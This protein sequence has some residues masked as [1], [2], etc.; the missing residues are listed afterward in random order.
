LL[1]KTWIEKDQI[2]RKV[3]EGDTEKKKKEL[4]DFIARK[5]DRLI[6]EQEDNSKKQNKVT[7]QE[8]HKERG[9]FINV[10][11]ME[12]VLKDLYIQEISMSTQEVLRKGVFTSDHLREP[13]QCEATALGEDKNKNGK[14]IPETIREIQIIRNKVRNINKKKISWKIY[15]NLQKS[16]RRLHRLEPRRKQVREI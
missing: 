16:Y 15:K 9:L 12:E 7:A 13:Q 2:K 5:I 1:G 3:E 6:D 4:R 10:E 14:R 8:G 11:R